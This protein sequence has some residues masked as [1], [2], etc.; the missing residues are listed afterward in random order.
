MFATRLR[1]LASSCEFA[2]V[3]KK[4]K[5]QI[6][7]SCSSSR[8][9]RRALREPTITLKSLLDLGRATELSETQASGIELQSLT[10][11]DA[12]E[13]NYTRT[14]QR[15]H[16]EQPTSR[17]STFGH[18]GN[19]YPQRLSKFKVS[20]KLCTKKGEFNK[21][22]IEFFVSPDPKKVTAITN[23]KYARSS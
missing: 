9:R 23:D 22:S 13:V 14:S 19:A 18:C 4:I 1:Q 2:S 7:L 10:P 20:L 17:S 12:T 15:S 16:F 5:S 3:D 6:I 8:L 11:F 21:S